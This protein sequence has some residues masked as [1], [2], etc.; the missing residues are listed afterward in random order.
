MI[1]GW[2]YMNNNLKVVIITGA[3]SLIGKE[4]AL[5]FLTANWKVHVTVRS[6]KTY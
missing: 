4:I 2:V 5:R 6:K 1:E 3:N